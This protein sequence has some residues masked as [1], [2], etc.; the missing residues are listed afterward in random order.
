MSGIRRGP[1]QGCLVGC[2]Q[3]LICLDN[4]LCQVVLNSQDKD[5]LILAY[6]FMSR[7]SYLPDMAALLASFHFTVSPTI[8]M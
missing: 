6:L 7:F 4:P 5:R 3:D 1:A 2:R 8:P